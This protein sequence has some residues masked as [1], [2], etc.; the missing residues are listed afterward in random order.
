[1]PLKNGKPE[2]GDY[3]VVLKDRTLAA[4]TTK[5]ELQGGR[6]TRGCRW[7]ALRNAGP[8]LPKADVPR[9]GSQRPFAKELSP[10]CQ[11]K[12]EPPSPICSH[13]PGRQEPPCDWGAGAA[14][15]G[16]LDGALAP[17]ALTFTHHSRSRVRDTAG[18]GDTTAVPVRVQ[19]VRAQASCHSPSTHCPSALP[20]PS[21]GR[22]LHV[23]GVRPTSSSHRLPSAPQGGPVTVTLCVPHTALCFLLGLDLSPVSHRVVISLWAVQCRFACLDARP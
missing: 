15:G 9:L 11:Q 3:R 12:V 10:R 6:G 13:G 14:A 2:K 8:W 4:E 5:M 19:V 20:R 17:A 18:P 16:Q 7:H 23:P 1:M 21:T 22:L